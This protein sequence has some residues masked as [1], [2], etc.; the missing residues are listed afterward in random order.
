LQPLADRV[1]VRE[2]LLGE[3]LA[4]DHDRFAT[5]AKTGL[6]LTGAAVVAGVVGLVMYL[7]DTTVSVEASSM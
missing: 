4:D 5:I 2:T 6:V 1:A 7:H 3:C